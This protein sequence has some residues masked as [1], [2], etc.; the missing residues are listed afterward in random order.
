[1][2][3]SK[4]NNPIRSSIMNVIKKYSI[5]TLAFFLI[6][7]GIMLYAALGNPLIA[8][9]SISILLLTVA[10]TA[11]LLGSIYLFLIKDTASFKKWQMM[12]LVRRILL[13]LFITAGVLL[14][15]A[16]SF[17]PDWPLFINFFAAPGIIPT[18][19]VATHFVVGGISIIV[20]TLLMH[21]VD[22]S[23][24]MPEGSTSSANRAPQDEPPEHSSIVPPKN[25][26]QLSPAANTSESQPT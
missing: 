26:E 7:I 22:I 19:S 20:T 14:I 18:L 17:L 25:N 5:W 4:A 8:G 11:L 16:A 21:A 24:N 9:V 2:P 23:I 10:G 13:G 12:S 15:L 6:D 3:E 1:M